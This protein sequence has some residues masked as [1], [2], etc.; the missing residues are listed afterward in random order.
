MLKRLIQ[1]LSPG[2]PSHDKVNDSKTVI[3]SPVIENKA[4]HSA[5]DLE[6]AGNQSLKANDLNQAE[7][8]CRQSIAINLNRPTAYNRLAVVL[9]YQNR[10]DEALS[11]YDQAIALNPD[12]ADAY[13]NRGIAL[14]AMK[15]LDLAI[16]SYDRVITLK[17][18][19]VNAYFNRGVILYSL[20]RPDEALDSYDR[21]IA[22]NPDYAEVYN[23]R[24]GAL[25]SLKHFDEALAS[26][27]RAIALNPDYANAHNNRGIALSAMK[28]YDQALISYD[29]AIALN[30]DYANAHNNRGT[31]LYSMKRYD[32]ALI[33]YDRAITLS[34]DYADA[35]NNRGTTLYS[36]KRYDQALI[37]YDRAITLNPDYADAYNNQ[38]IALN[39]IKHYDQALISYDR[40]IALI[41]DYA[42][43]YNNRG[44]TLYS[45]KRYDQA[46]ISYDRAIALNPDYA[47]AHNNRG[48]ALSALKRFEEA[49]ASYDHAIALNPDYADA[50]NNLGVAFNTLNR[51]GEAIVSYDHAIMLDPNCAS[52]YYNR[53]VALYSLR[54]FSD[55][56]DSYEHA[57]ALK[58]D[59]VD[60]HNNRGAVLDNMKRLDETLASYG[61]ALALEPDY[62]FL[63]GH[64]L[65]TKI[66]LCDWSNYDSQLMQLSDKIERN[67]K[68][69]PPFALL[70]LP[71]SRCLQK[72]AAE[73]FMQSK[74]PANYSLQKITKHPKKK[75]IRIGYFSADFYNHPV[76]FLT[77]ELFEMHDKSKFELIA[78]AFGPNRKDEMRKRVVAAFDH[79]IYVG[80]Q[81]DQEVAMKARSL[82]IDLGGFTGSCRAGIFALRAA[83]IQVS[84][85]GYLGTMGA[86]YIDY[87]I[88]DATIVPQA[89]QKD[90]TEKIVYLPSYQV[91][92]S[93]RSISDRIFN[94]TELGLPPTGFV[95]CCLNNSY[96]ITPSTFDSWMHILKQV[97]G[98]VLWLLDENPTAVIN[99][100]KEA[101]IRG[102]DGK[103]L[104]FAKRLPLP[105]YL[106]RYRMADLFLDTSP[107]NAG[108]TASDALWAGLPV[109]TQLGETF[110]SRMAASL[111]NAIE[112][113]ELITNSQQD[114][115]TLAIELA[116]NQDKLAKIKQKLAD[117]RLTTALF[118]TQQCT[119]HIE[120]AYTQV[121]ER[122]QSGLP[123]S[124]ID[125]LQKVS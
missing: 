4:L 66:R 45:M 81:S 113:P 60:A 23:A 115:E 79:F 94:R 71:S 97:E 70:S 22:L 110:A 73:I 87:L 51:F 28:R 105:E 124:H 100:R 3:Q 98:S 78:F 102:V 91:N 42:D 92:D 35:Y 61:H 104:I 111:L 32:Q 82:E 13:Y 17:P 99:L 74:Y 33:S 76:S 6:D 43:A 14:N 86:E 5:E 77:A 119:K 15:H 49:I 62:A 109:I 121:Y 65:H 112:L 12:Y 44:T 10:L 31:T 63:F 125:S 47:D 56:L 9:Y 57:I 41:P 30:P 75:K 20:N 53:G 59:Y 27:D 118:D 108:T 18:D 1:L 7:R 116:M 83:P 34:P 85:L 37:S 40:A 88:A 46:L 93:K 67:Q 84:Y 29:R 50:H 122:C 80:D 106:A 48:T 114:Y 89:H 107:Y 90:Y 8:Y 21:A 16:T 64:W 24:G 2:Q 103:R 68:T 36:M 101:S 26:Y 120:A 52:T 55:A 72:K 95:F 19:Y 38:G 11:N 96:K 58:P 54:Y 117:N 39:A 25:N 69:V 123:P